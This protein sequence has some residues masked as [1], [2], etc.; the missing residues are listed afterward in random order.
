MLWKVAS[1]VKPLPV[2]RV[3][4]WIDV[5]DLAT[6][7]VEALTSANVDGKRYIPASPERFSYGIA[8]QIISS[9]FPDLK[10]GVT[11]ENQAIDLSCGVDGE[12]ASKE[13]GF[14]YR[15]FED[16]VRD[17]ISQVVLLNKS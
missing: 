5:R 4:F 12:T 16:T 8:A 10:D 3:P 6:A 11:Q 7:H 9:A 15:S 13:L 17:L 14:T 2:S 1:G